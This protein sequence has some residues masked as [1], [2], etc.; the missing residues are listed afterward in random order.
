MLDYLTLGST[1]IEEDCVQVNRDGD[2]LEAMRAECARYCEMLRKRFPEAAHLI[3]MKRFSHDFGPYFK[4]CV[5]FDDDDE[6]QTELAYWVENDPPATWT[7][8][9]VVTFPSVE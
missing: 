6:K 7:D 5:V 4:A 1:P 3:R 9:A 8:D 2:Y